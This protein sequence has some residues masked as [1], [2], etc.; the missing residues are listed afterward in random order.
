MEKTES[1][2]PVLWN[3]I[4]KCG[5]NALHLREGAAPTM[6]IGAT[7]LLPISLD[8]LSKAGYV[9]KRGQGDLSHDSLAALIKEVTPDRYQAELHLEEPTGGDAQVAFPMS[10]GDLVMFSIIITRKDDELAMSTCVLAPQVKDWH[11]F[12]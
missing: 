2:V 4:L 3:E 1:F 6:Q 10:F 9:G 5:A 8:L 12:D 11:R 7:I